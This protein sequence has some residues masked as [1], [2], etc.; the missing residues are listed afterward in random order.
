MQKL[1]IKKENEKKF[2]K[3]DKCLR[4][5]KQWILRCSPEKKKRDE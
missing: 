5:L 1:F 2:K 3:I 4:Y